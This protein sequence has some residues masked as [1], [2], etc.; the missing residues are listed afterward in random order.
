MRR[1]GALVWLVGCSTL[2]GTPQEEECSV[3]EDCPDDQDCLIEQ[4]KGV[5]RETSA[6]PPVAYIAFDVE[7]D[8]GGELQFR[9]EVAGCDEVIDIR[10]SERE[11]EAS[12][13]IVSQTLELRVFALEPLDAEDPTPQEVLE[14]TIEVSTPSRFVRTPTTQR[15]S[16]EHPTLDENDNIVDTRIRWPRYNPDDALPDALR[17]GFILWTTTP[18]DDAAPMYQMLLPPRT[19][20]DTTCLTD[21]ECC[22]GSCEADDV[23]TVCV[24]E[25]GQCRPLNN[26][27]TRYS[28]I[29]DDA[30]D[31]RVSG[32]VVLVDDALATLRPI[33]GATI[34]LRH[35][36]VDGQPRLG[37]H[38]LDL[39]TPIEDRPP[40]CTEDDECIQDEQFC[41]LDTNQCVLSLAGRT[42]NKSATS[43]PEGAFDTRVFTYCTGLPNGLFERAFS[44]TVSP[45]AGV[46][47]PTVNYAVNV[48]FT[49]PE[50]AA[51]AIEKPL[52][53]PAWGEPQPL[54]LRVRGNARTLVAGGTGYKCCDV[55]CLPATVE[56]V[57]DDP[58]SMNRCSGGRTSS[59]ESPVIRV[60]T[61]LQMTPELDALW[62]DP[63]SPCA[64]PSVDATGAFGVLSEN[65][66]CPPDSDQCFL[67]SLASG[68]VDTPRIYSVRIES[69]EGSVLQSLDTQIDMT[70]LT[71][72]TMD[73]DLQPRRLVRGFVT[74]PEAL[75]PEEDEVEGDCGS[76]GAVVLAERLRMSDETVADVPPPYFH[77]IT[78]FYDPASEQPGAYIM[79]LD[80]GVYVMTALPASGSAGGPADLVIVDV[81][82]DDLEV[83][84]LLKAGLLVT[85][86]ASSFDRR[87]EVVPLDT[88]SWKLLDPPLAN[89]T[90]A[91][92]EEDP[93]SCALD[94]DD[95]ETCL[96]ATDPGGGTPACLIRR[97]VPSGLSLTQVGQVRF[98]VRDVGGEIA[99][100]NCTT[101]PE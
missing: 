13:A 58:N 63:D 15:R 45:A 38:A 53:V 8:V 99:T 96:V 22:E 92:D 24:S 55:G 78:T 88:G 3:Q 87:A 91:C 5:C 39:S 26:P 40:Q 44:A 33:E 89:P 19:F 80:P 6:L 75:C 25:L 94:L 4:G 41:D 36:D 35:E 98:R 76:E 62:R 61:P 49:P 32:D 86:D 51:G 97:I 57:E 56:D 101:A 43:N 85:L 28:F 23:P 67:E 10:S 73:I 42:A 70:S 90:I 66:D 69:P 83:D 31:R 27:E 60:E 72:L 20:T 77:E 14:A 52:C 1:L 34:Q 18:T 9:V 50:G 54:A 64:E 11:I 95:P 29:Y 65:A 17:E 47:L 71:P 84:F 93:A 48:D 68:T 37:V 79:P 81:T 59:G 30:C 16:I 74:V 46:P 2:A 7:E 100:R 12:R 82:E 21:V